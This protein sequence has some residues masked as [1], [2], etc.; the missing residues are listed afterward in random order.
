[1]ISN[2][3]TDSNSTS[4]QANK[5]TAA[6]HLVQSSRWARRLAKFLLAGLVVSIIAMGVLPWQQTSRGSGR[7]VAFAP[8]ERQ[9]SVQ[10]PTKGIVAKIA[11]GLVEGSL[12]KK[13]D[14]LLEVQPFAA[15]MVE[16][17]GGQLNELKTKEE[18]AK[19]KAE[20]YGQNIEGFTEALEFAMSAAAELV[21]AAKAKLQS[22]KNQIRAYEAKELQARLN[23]ERQKGLFR[24]GLKPAKEIEKL[25]KEWDVALADAESVQQD[26]LGLQNELKAKQ[27][28][29]EEKRRVAQT[30]I[31]YARAMQQ[32]AIGSAATIR[33]EIAD[34]KMKLEE[35]SRLTITAPRDGTVFRLNVNERGDSVKQGDTLLTIVPET[36]RKAVELFVN[37]NDMPLMELGQEVRLQFEGW[38]A[39]QFAGWP[40]VAVGTFSGTVSTVDAT[41]NGKGQFRILITPNEDEQEWPSDRYLR[42]GVRANGW[43]MLRRVSLGY[44]IWRQLNGFPVIVAEKEPTKE[45]VKPPKLPK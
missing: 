24:R 33:K 13:G 40:S 14:F 25:K 36:T 10:A 4:L 32:D 44:E 35:M 18:T 7:V 6:V 9:Q 41:D 38:P 23:Y 17:L 3:V 11:D 12:V 16:Q 45:K 27:E 39:V 15:N 42:Q 5:R 20:A 37:G 22:K 8:Q 28:E 26:V 43:V 19:V 30:K 29:L 21:S 1:M 2:R 31:D 34:V